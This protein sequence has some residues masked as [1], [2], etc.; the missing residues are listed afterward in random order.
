MQAPQSGDSRVF[1]AMLGETNSTPSSLGALCIQSRRRDFASRQGPSRVPSQQENFSTT[2]THA[3]VVP[4][5]RLFCI[6]NQHTAPSLHLA[7]PT[8]GSP[9]P[10]GFKNRFGTHATHVRMSA[11]AHNRAVSPTLQSVSQPSVHARGATLARLP[12]VA[13]SNAALRSAMQTRAH[14][15]AN[16]AVSRLLQSAHAKTQNFPS[17]R[18][19]IEQVF[20]EKAYT[21][22]AL[23]ALLEKH[24]KS[25]VRYDSA[26]RL[27][28][29]VGL[30]MGYSFPDVST[31]QV[32][33]VLSTIYAESAPQALPFRGAPIVFLPCIPCSLTQ[34]SA[35]CAKDGTNPLQSTRFFGRAKHLWPACLARR[36][37]GRP[38]F[39]YVPVSSLCY[40]CFN[41]TALL[42]AP[43][44][45]VY[46]ATLMINGLYPRVEK[47]GPP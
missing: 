40:A 28:C 30:E 36:W 3:S 6:S 38:V 4:R 11:M 39:N 24:S 35:L 7:L 25:K 32:A 12:L 27:F 10:G 20:K 21:D 34:P 37:I 5:D 29:A 19:I 23:Q 26:F 22:T 1:R 33:S 16:G 18:C 41:F 31:A 46:G 14:P 8:S 2:H 44:W 17:L 47:V 45:C 13:S 15:A 43:T 9:C 42:I